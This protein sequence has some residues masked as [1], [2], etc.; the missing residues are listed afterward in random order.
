MG[1]RSRLWGPHLV[2]AG[3]RVRGTMYGVYTFLEDVLGCRWYTSKVSVIPKKPTITLGP[4]NIVQKPSF[5]YRNDYYADAFNQDWAARQKSN[6]ITDEAHGGSIVYGRFVHTFYALVPAEKYFKDHPKYYALI[7]GKRIAASPSMGQLCLSN[8][9][10][11]KI[12]TQ[13]VLDWC[14]SNP[15]AKI[16]SVSQ[17]DYG[18]GCQCD[19]CR[20]IDAEEGSPSG[21]LLRFVNAIADEVAKQYPNVLIDTL[22]YQ[23]TEEPPRI[24]GLRPNVR[25]RL[26]PISCCEVHPYD[27]CDFGDNQRFMKRFERWSQMTDNLYIWHYS[28]AFFNLLLPFPDEDQLAASLRMY[29]AHGVKGIFME[30]NNF[31]GGHMDELKAYLVAKLMWNVNADPRAIREEFLTGYFGKAG[32]PIDEWLDLLHSEVAKRNIHMNPWPN[33]PFALFTPQV[34]GKSDLLFD[35]A[36]KLADSPEILARVKHARLSLRYAKLWRDTCVACNG[37]IDDK[38]AVYQSWLDFVKDCKADGIEH[39]SIEG[40]IDDYPNI[41]ARSMGLDAK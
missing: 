17:D 19:K 28:T 1:L 23:Y 9:E 35:T 13:T 29:K 16:W 4:L 37:T 25:V 38:K 2:I 8:P 18:R 10:V 34:L 6:G 30:G 40:A 7:D 5:E 26:C 3:S 31:A 27:K 20:A 15:K 12:A 21:T 32:R 22:A 14:K 41:P 39:L 36:E 24:T 33:P 11:L